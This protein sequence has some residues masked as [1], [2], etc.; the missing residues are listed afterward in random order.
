MK[1]IYIYINTFSLQHAE[2]LKVQLIL[3]G[4]TIS[5]LQAHEQVF[6]NEIKYV[7]NFFSGQLFV[8]SDT[9]LKLSKISIISS[10]QDSDLKSDG[11]GNHVRFELIRRQ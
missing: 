4:S 11:R 6:C 2:R 10:P 3:S 9:T 7:C 5:K 1:Y 8:S